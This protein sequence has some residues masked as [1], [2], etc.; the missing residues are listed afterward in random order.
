[1]NHS[2]QQEALQSL[3]E[4]PVK[5]K[6]K[7]IVLLNFDAIIHARTRKITWNKIAESLGLQRTTLINAVRCL[8]QSNMKQEDG[9]CFSKEVDRNEKSIASNMSDAT[10]E[11]SLKEKPQLKDQLLSNESTGLKTLGRAKRENFNL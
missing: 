4:E 2:K 6:T 3:I 11:L 1:M 9:L 5:L 7:D 10:A 8:L